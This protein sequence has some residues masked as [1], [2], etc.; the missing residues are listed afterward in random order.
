MRF[1][2]RTYWLGSLFLSNPR[3]EGARSSKSFLNK[4]S[5]RLFLDIMCP[6]SG[7]FRWGGCSLCSGTGLPGIAWHRC[8]VLSRKKEWLNPSLANLASNRSETL[9]ED[10]YKGYETKGK[11]YGMSILVESLLSLTTGSTPIWDSQVEPSNMHQHS[12][13][14]FNSSTTPRD[15]RQQECLQLVQSKH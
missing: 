12:S 7:P 2:L 8:I 11:P 9:L 14:S 15:S 3:L 4:Y 5:N 10:S 13:T 1:E 6:S